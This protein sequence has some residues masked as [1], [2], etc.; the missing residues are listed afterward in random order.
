MCGEG[1]E[2]AQYEWTLTLAANVAWHGSKVPYKAGQLDNPGFAGVAN[3]NWNHEGMVA[4]DDQQGTT[5]DHAVLYSNGHTGHRGAATPVDAACASVYPEEACKRGNAQGL[6]PGGTQAWYNGAFGDKLTVKLD[7]AAHTFAVYAYSKCSTKPFPDE[8]RASGVNSWCDLPMEYAALEKEEDDELQYLCEMS[9]PDT[10]GEVYA[11]AGGQSKLNTF[12]LNGGGKVL[13]QWVARPETDC[14]TYCGLAAGAPELQ[15]QATSCVGI[16]SGE[17]MSGCG[18][19]APITTCPATAACV[20]Q[21]AAAPAC[22]TDCWEEDTEA[23]A[24][25]YLSYPKCETTDGSNPDADVE[26]CTSPQPTVTCYAT[27][28]CTCFDKE[29]N[30]GETDVDCGGDLCGPCSCGLD[31]S[32]DP[33]GKCKT[34]TV[35]EVGESQYRTYGSLDVDEVFKDDHPEAAKKVGLTIGAK[36][37]ATDPADYFEDVNRFVHPETLKPTGAAEAINYESWNGRYV[38]PCEQKFKVDDYANRKERK[39]ANGK[40]HTGPES[41]VGETDY[42][43]FK[44]IKLTVTRPTDWTAPAKAYDYFQAEHL[45]MY[46]KDQWTVLRAEHE[47]YMMNAYGTLIPLPE[48]RKKGEDDGSGGVIGDGPAEGAGGVL[49]QNTNSKSA[50]FTVF[51]AA[52]DTGDFI[53]RYGNP[54][55]VLGSDGVTDCSDTVEMQANGG[56]IPKGCGTWTALEFSKTV[57]RVGTPWTNCEVASEAT[58]NTAE[59]GAIFPAYFGHPNLQAATYTAF[60]DAVKETDVPTYVILDI[61]SPDAGAVN[62]EDEKI[63]FTDN[64]AKWTFS[65]SGKGTRAGYSKGMTEYTKCFPAG[66]ACPDDFRKCDASHCNID[67]WGAFQKDLRGS[68]AKISTLGFIETRKPSVGDA[69]VLVQRSEQEI[70]DD[71]KAYHLYEGAQVD[72]FY[73]NRVDTND[74][75]GSVNVILEIAAEIRDATHSNFQGDANKVVV[76]GTGTALSDEEVIGKHDAYPAAENHPGKP[77][78]VV[79][80]TADVEDKKNWHPYSWFPTVGPSQWGALL[81]NV[82]Q[83]QVTEMAKLMFDRGYGYI[84]LHSYAASYRDAD[85]ELGPYSK[86]SEHVTEILAAIKDGWK[87]ITKDGRRLQAVTDAPDVFQW[88]CDATLF[89][90]GAVC[91]RTTG[92]TTMIVSDAQCEGVPDKCG[93]QCLFEAAWTCEGEKVVCTAK[94]TTTLERRRVGD[95]VC[96]SR[97]TAKP[98]RAGFAEAVLDQCTPQYV[99]AGDAPAGVCLAFYEERVVKRKAAEDAALEAELNPTPAAVEETVFVEEFAFDDIESV[100]FPAALFA[101]AALYA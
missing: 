3:G 82:G 76:F 74:P 65:G 67:K 33:D 94:D 68:N 36:S 100:A 66:Q 77:N 49:G 44:T 59:I 75:D 8:L 80:V 73:F 29:K 9:Y 10:W 53:F 18:G 25:M 78:I 23:S 88:S 81:T 55:L 22:P 51:M 17:E 70:R 50:E 15:L 7:C 72:G 84:G 21:W 38:L 63:V 35:R 34:F 4:T 20:Y 40:L 48:L 11:A 46:K 57:L 45:N 95:L 2:E 89:H 1:D 42:P 47:P 27:M 6:C 43:E 92:T 37:R 60:K 86:V 69:S 24:T 83:G 31:V 90:C 5:S 30:G 97:G 26:L 93:C 13:S 32:I 64:H 58:K 96:S 87:E 61:F 91:M 16:E 14:P 52:P 56:E 19:T 99:A 41:T 71:V 85:T 39:D 79:A 54:N 62:N 98:A 101:L 28:P 12:I